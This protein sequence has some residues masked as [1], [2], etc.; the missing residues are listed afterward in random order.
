MTHEHGKLPTIALAICSPTLPSGPYPK[1]TWATA[2][3]MFP[4][5]R[6]ASPQRVDASSFFNRPS[7]S[8]R[9]S[10]GRGWPIYNSSWSIPA[11][12]SG[13]FE[14]VVLDMPGLHPQGVVQLE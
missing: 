12:R 8:V 11:T 14:L 13:C 2:V 6:P 5:S 4:G 7:P 10:F 1:E 9:W 3:T